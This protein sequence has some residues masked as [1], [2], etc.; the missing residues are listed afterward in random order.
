MRKRAPA[1]TTPVEAEAP[2]EPSRRLRSWGP[3]ALVRRGERGTAVVEFALIAPLLFLLVGGILDFARAMNY[4]N[5]M[6]QL[7]GQGARAAIVASN[8][9]GT[10]PSDATSV[11]CQLINSYTTSAE[12]K[13]STGTNG[14]QVQIVDPNNPSAATVNPVAGQPLQV[15]TSFDFDFVVP[16]VKIGI[17]GAFLH[18][19]TSSTMR[20]EQRAA[21]A[22]STAP[23]N[24]TTC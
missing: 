3:L 7:A 15:K 13:G 22:F 4:Y 16:L 11:Q 8:P 12:L 1:T 10:A 23:Q 24:V 19:S 6:T 18:L 17:S 21:T 9:D 2:R 5:D 20:V 14:I